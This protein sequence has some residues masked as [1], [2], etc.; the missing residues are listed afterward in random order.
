MNGEI[1]MK[2][3]ALLA[4]LLAMSL[5][6]SSCALIVKDPAVD[7]ATVILKLGDREVTKA[8]VQRSTTYYLNQ[9]EQ[10]YAMFGQNL[11]I[12]SPDVLASAQ[13]TAVAQLKQDMVLRAKS[14]ELQLDQLT[15]EE[16]AS[17]E[18]DAQASWEELKD[19]IKNYDLSDEEKALEGEEL[20]AAIQA[21]LD[22]YGIKYES[23][24]S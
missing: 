13:D 11:D 7:A 19:D 10:Y 21:K 3:K 9:M 18:E 23:A 17:A 4:V 8:E 2:K 16:L 24:K 20:E 15:E 12:T 5:L 6:L 22:E 1:P 14:A